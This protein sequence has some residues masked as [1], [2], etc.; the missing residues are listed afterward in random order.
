MTQHKPHA[1]G[2][3]EPHFPNSSAQQ[4]KVLRNGDRL[5]HRSFLG[6]ERAFAAFALSSR[7]ITAAAT[8]PYHFVNARICLAVRALSNASLERRDCP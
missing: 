4:G 6:S 2:A 1:I 3:T 7:W 8:S 5:S